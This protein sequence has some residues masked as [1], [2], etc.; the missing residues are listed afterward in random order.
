MNKENLDVN[1]LLNLAY[2]AIQV[3]NFDNAKNLFEKIIS[4][5]K[6]IPEVYNNLGSIYLNSNNFKKAIEC[7]NKSISLNPKF[8]AAFCN[9]GIAY[10]KTGDFKSS[11]INYIKSI[12]L[13]KK[14]IVSH[15][16]LGNLYKDK[17]DI[18]N[19]EKYYN[20]ALDLKP[21]MLQ[22]YTNLFFI[23]NRSNQFE[24]LGEVLT[25]AKNNLGKNPLV[26]FFTGIFNFESKNYEYVI[27]NFEKL[28]IP[29]NKINLNVNKNELLAKSYDH[30]GKY[31]KAYDHFVEA[32]T[33]IN[34]SF[35]E[36]FKKERYIDTVNKRL[37]FFSE[38]E[39]KKWSL[40]FS[41]ER[42]PFFL[43]GFPRSGT[44]LL[45]TILR[46][47]DGIEVIEE[48]PILDK[49]I[50]TLKSE[51]NNDFSKLEKMDEKFFNKMR[52]TYFE[53]RNKYIKFDKN[54]IYIDKLPLN[55]IF[56]G[57][58]YRFFPNAKF[59]IALR[60]PYDVTL[61]CFMQQFTPND[62]MM[63]FISLNDAVQLY[64]LVMTL[65]LKYK[66]LFNSNIYE[67][68]YE[69]VVTNFDKSIK[70]LLNFLDIEWQDKMKKFYE[71]ASKRGI[72][73]TPSF[74]QVNKK[75]YN[76]SMDRWKNYNKKFLEIEHSLNK[77][78]KEFNY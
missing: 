42:G 75:L 10:Y 29:K 74:N 49:F 41:E 78:I 67:I 63:N 61:S 51:I 34:E 23:Y 21:D 40:K 36:E 25:K 47:H 46:S 76:K 9:L 62:A 69:N 24:K 45:D 58:I 59:I 7:F 32:N 68:K 71:T 31:E 39:L 48:K 3:K 52:K 11:E 64:D 73:S 6:N 72:I 18:S 2:K 16:N 54:K 77:W 30:I 65:Y 4:I 5:N 50:D 27:E 60:N 12:S 35:K 37:T 13:D 22:A 19:A 8:S 43:L 26:D 33:L 53:E 14:N 55:I 38:F 66:R 17:N 70:D 28:I 56:I 20:F 15:F 44:T 1:Q 57:E